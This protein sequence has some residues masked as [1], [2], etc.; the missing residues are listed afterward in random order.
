MSKKKLKIMEMIVGVNKIF[1]NENCL[2]LRINFYIIL[3]F[4]VYLSLIKFK[5]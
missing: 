2:K 5:F 1:N 3:S 4:I